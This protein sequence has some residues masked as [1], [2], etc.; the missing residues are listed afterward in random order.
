MYECF[1][2]KLKV[3]FFLHLG[4]P[5]V[6]YTFHYGVVAAKDESAFEDDCQI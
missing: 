3:N 6:V 4:S 5:T 2:C 1:C